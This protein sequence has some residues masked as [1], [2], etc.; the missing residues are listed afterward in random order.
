M[1]G[2]NFIVR[3][4]NEVCV[5]DSRFKGYFVYYCYEDFVTFLLS[6]HFYFHFVCTTTFKDFDHGIFRE[7]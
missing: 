6:N 3:L 4:T 2:C 1:A 7:L 5:L